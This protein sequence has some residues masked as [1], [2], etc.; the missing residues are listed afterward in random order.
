MFG[1]LLTLSVIVATP[2]GSLWDQ[3]QINAAFKRANVILAA[4]KVNV[5]IQEVRKDVPDEI[6]VDYAWTPFAAN[7]VKDK[8]LPVIFLTDHS[9]ENGSVGLAPGPKYLFLSSDSLTQEYRSIRDSNY[10]PLAHELGHML[11]NLK[12]LGSESGSNLMSGYTSLVNDQL[13]FKQCQEIRKNSYFSLRPLS[14][15][16]L[17]SLHFYE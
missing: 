7:Y 2:K 11:G 13:T 17:N 14:T 15:D 5:V 6:A 3:K 16:I 1:L 4:C 10:E 8:L 12:H 9:Q